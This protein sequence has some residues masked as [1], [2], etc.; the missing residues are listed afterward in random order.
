MEGR[1]SCNR[2]IHQTEHLSAVESG[3]DTRFGTAGQDTVN[4]GRGMV[5][6]GMQ[7]LLN[8]REAAAILDMHPDTVYTL[9][10]RGDLVGIK[11]PGLRGNWKIQQSAI[12]RFILRN[13]YRP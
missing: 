2:P 10:R 7:K 11:M 5:N 8:V 6:Y 4:P 12:E 3:Q 13:T 9:L 1:T